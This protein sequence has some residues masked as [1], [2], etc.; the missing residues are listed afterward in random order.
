MTVAMK[1]WGNSLA[2][3]IPK[4]IT[5]S[6]DLR[7]DSLLELEIR[8]NTLVLKP[9][10]NNSLEMMVEQITPENLHNEIKTDEAIGHE[11]W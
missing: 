5:A 4:D 6:L 1:R 7:D 11:E 8:D 2:I 3:R 10:Q 9:K